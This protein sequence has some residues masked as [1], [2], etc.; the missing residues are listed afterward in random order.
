MAAARL[1]GD[2]V[3]ELR[4]AAGWLQADLAAQLGTRDRRVGEWERGEQQPQPRSVAEL[5]A[6]FQVDPLALLDVDPDDPPL[7]ALRLAAGLTLTE[8]ASAS[9]VPYSTYRRLE[10]G[11]LRGEPAAP[12]VK[13]LAPVLQVGVAKLRKA[14]QRSQMDHRTGP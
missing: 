6:A 3:A 8:V 7:L 9:S 14:M 4:K 1:R 5:A 10:G 2:L 13:A 12:V 11:L